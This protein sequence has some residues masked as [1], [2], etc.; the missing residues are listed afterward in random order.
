MHYVQPLSLYQVD[1]LRHQATKIVSTRLGRAEPPLRKENVEYMLD[2]GSH[3]F[4]MRR[5]KA[6]Y[7]RIVELISGLR[8]AMK[9]F[10]EICLW[11]NPFTTILIHILFLL[12]ALFPELI[13]PLMFFYLLAIG[14]WRF[15]K[16]PRHPPHMEV[17]LSL[18]DTVV[19]DE[20][21]EEFDS[22]PTSQQA[23]I[24][25]LRY[26]RIRSVASR[27]QG[28]M[29]D[30]ATQ[31]ERLQALLSWRDPRA[32]ALCMI[33]SLTAGIMF[34]LIPFQV[35]SV[36]VVLYVLRHP[37][38]RHRM[39]SVPLNFFKRLPARTDSMFWDLHWWPLGVRFFLGHRH[40][41]HF[42]FL[43]EV[44][45]MFEPWLVLHQIHFISITDNEM[46]F[47]LQFFQQ[48]VFLEVGKLFVLLSYFQTQTQILT[49]QL[50]VNCRCKNMI[51]T[52]TLKKLMKSK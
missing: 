51:L 35:F 13:L 27:I 26:D 47:N 25:K 30:L 21:A 40:K 41:V 37:R 9:W 5:T 34:L 7:Y 19:H 42:K 48:W 43:S 46:N 33:F 23:E 38:L 11:K 29:G 22:F 45:S 2:V 6:N 52:R 8:I 50:K 16:R 1:S 4:S 15:R 28:L 10:N 3:M 18:P 31:G 17:R 36:L 32:T 49:I 12:L 44:R 39:P 24:I 20:L 14:I